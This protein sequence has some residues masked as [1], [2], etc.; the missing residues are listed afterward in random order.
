META[1]DRAREAE[2]LATGAIP[3]HGSTLGDPNAPVTIVEFVDLRCGP[4]AKV[5]REYLPYL[6]DEYVRTGRARLSLVALAQEGRRS[7]IAQSI[8][9]LVAAKDQSWLFTDFVF[10]TERGSQNTRSMDWGY[11]RPILTQLPGV[12]PSDLMPSHEA[13]LR[14]VQRRHLRLAQRLGVN[15]TPYFAVGRSTASPSSYRPIQAGLHIP[16]LGTIEDAV[17]AAEGP[18]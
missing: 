12:T 10:R 4:A 7:V 17:N 1:A 2:V 14:K 5:H 8:F 6:I 15:G 3:V 9:D 18:V 11:L 13:A 16:S